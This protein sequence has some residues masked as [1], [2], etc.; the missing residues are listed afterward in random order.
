M[1]K[2]TA[3]K[4]ALGSASFVGAHVERFDMHADASLPAAKVPR[5]SDG[6]GASTNSA[7]PCTTDG[8]PTA[9]VL[10][11]QLTTNVKG[12]DDGLVLEEGSGS[13][14]TTPCQVAAATAPRRVVGAAHLLPDVLVL[15]FARLGV[16]DLA[17]AARVC[18]SW[19]AVIDS[20]SR[21]WALAIAELDPF[22]SIGQAGMR[23]AFVECGH[24]WLSVARTLTAPHMGCAHGGCDFVGTVLCACRRAV[25]RSAAAAAAAGPTPP[26]LR[27][28]RHCINSG[29]DGACTHVLNSWIMYPRSLGLRCAHI[30]GDGGHVA[31]AALAAAACDAPQLCRITTSGRFTFGV[32]GIG[33]L[34]ITSS[35]V[36]DGLGKTVISTAN[37]YNVYVAAPCV[38]LV[39]M[40][41]ETSAREPEYVGGDFLFYSTMELNSGAGL[42]LTNV[43]VLSHSG[44]ALLMHPHS[45]AFVADCTLSSYTMDYWRGVEDPLCLGIVAE[46]H[47]ALSVYGCRIEHC[48]WGAFA[49]PDAGALKA[50]NIFHRNDEDISKADQYPEGQQVVQPYGTWK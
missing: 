24:S 4:S 5:L 11:Q 17:R 30:S 15:A 19:H 22:Y 25:T 33:G 16:V 45:R 13:A 46:A 39:N 12:A 3:L 6:A 26:R 14:V 35:I 42:I 48:M 21:A 32:G 37:Q 41:I 43:K 18:T 7:P 1:S 20:D 50:D 29:K 40:T 31:S 44:T 49:G 2:R 47:C 28:L 8:Q 34:L 38:S 9:D 10:Q 27:C 36:I 23:A